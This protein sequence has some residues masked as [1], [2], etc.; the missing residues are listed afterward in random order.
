MI[1]SHQKLTVTELFN[2]SYQIPIY[3]RNF[4]WTYNEIEQLIQDIDDAC[5]EQKEHYYIGTLVVDSN[6][7]IIDGQQR[8]TA[9]V[10]IALALQN[11]YSQTILNQIP[12]LFNGRKGSN[13]TL[14][15]MLER[16]MVDESNEIS[17]GYNN[18]KSILKLVDDKIAFTNYFLNRVIIFQSIL[19]KHLDLNLYFERFNSRGKQLEAHEVIKAQMMSKLDERTSLKF[20][21]IWDACSEFDKPVVLYFKKKSKYTDTNCE[22]EIIFPTENVGYYSFRH[23]FRIGLSQNFD[24]IEI[25]SENKQT[26][27]EYIETNHDSAK[28]ATDIAFEEDINYRTIINFETFLYYVY[29]LTTGTTD[30]EKIQLDDKKLLKTFEEKLQANNA[31]EFV[32]SFA[33][34][35]LQMKF[36]FDNF[37]IRSSLETRSDGRRQEGE[38]FLQKVYREDVNQKH[39]GHRYVQYRFDKNTF[40]QYNKEILMLQSMFAV[41]FSSNRDSRWLFEIVQFLYHHIDDLHQDDFAKVFFEM[42]ETMAISYAKS[43]VFTDDSFSKIKSYQ[44][45]ISIYA[46]NLIDYILWKNRERLKEHY[47]DTNHFNFSYRRSIEHWYPQHP[48]ENLGKIRLEDEFLHSIGNLA[49]ITDGQNSKFSNLSPQSK[50]NEWKRIFS[51]QSLKLQWMAKVTDKRTKEG[52]DWNKKDISEFASIIEKEMIAFINSK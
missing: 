14:N 43:R 24:E 46:F 35:M 12:I 20:A 11:E 45:G 41:T 2:N 18:V 19:P 13:Y 3:Q 30:L 48:T 44:E 16:K 31:K 10:M 4:S 42:L 28:T 27:M 7:N 39:R 8:A 21:K 25:N 32:M 22:R 9:L 38:W 37:I 29:Y 23:I 5:I 51:R 15:I 50:Y 6:Y 40:S 26:L 36:I 1:E 34:N 33:Y 49:I 17:R 47:F 52:H